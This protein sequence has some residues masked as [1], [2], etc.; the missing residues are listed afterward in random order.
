MNMT[1]Q[2]VHI[3]R[4][5]SPAATP[6]K[7]SY[8]LAKWGDAARAGF[9]IVPNV[10]FRAQ[11]YLELDSAEVVVLLNLALHWWAADSLPFPSPAIIAKRMGVSKRTIERRLE[12]LEK[13]GFIKRLAATEELQRR[14]ELSG[15]VEKLERAAER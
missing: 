14:Y 5:T 6:A 12:A 15:L 10:L 2:L 1:S 3:P 11:Q 7:K 4:A 8:Q 13:K 9:Q